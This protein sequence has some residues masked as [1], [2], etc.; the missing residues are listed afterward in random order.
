[1]GA[2]TIGWE[3][4]KLGHGKRRRSSDVVVQVLDR[5]FAGESSLVARR[6]TAPLD[7]L[8]CRCVRRT[9]TVIVPTRRRLVPSHLVRCN[10][11]LLVCDHLVLRNQALP[12]APPPSS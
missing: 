7:H 3:R 9:C 6:G 8:P 11:M 2:W 10:E 5:G 12:C 4:E 1:M